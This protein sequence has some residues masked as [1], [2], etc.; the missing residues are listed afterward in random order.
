MP[1]LQ[2]PANVP[3]QAEDIPAQMRAM[4]EEDQSRRVA[5]LQHLV[6]EM[7]RNKSL[8]YRDAKEDFEEESNGNPFFPHQVGPYII[9][10]QDRAHG[11]YV[12]PARHHRQIEADEYHRAAVKQYEFEHPWTMFFAGDHRRMDPGFW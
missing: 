6:D 3:S 7:A 2:V 9:P 12:N 4:E 11:F 1:P 8:P 10:G 5:L